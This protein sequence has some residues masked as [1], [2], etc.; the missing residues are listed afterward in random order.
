MAVAS[1]TG[2][3]TLSENADG[4]SWIRG[5][6]GPRTVWTLWS[7]GKFVASTGNRTHV[8]ACVSRRCMDWGVPALKVDEPYSSSFALKDWLMNAFLQ[9]ATSEGFWRW[10][11]TLK[12]HWVS[13]LCP[14]SDILRN[15]KRRRLGNRMCF[16]LRVR[17]ERILI[18]WVSQKELS[19]IIVVIWHGLSSDWG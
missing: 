2:R 15:Y 8:V 16:R 3:L 18:C 4:P 9:I 7:K 5:W 6:L 13:G 14:S 17:G 12:S 11:I 10:C 19:S 1:L